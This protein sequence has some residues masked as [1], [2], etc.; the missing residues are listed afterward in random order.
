MSSTTQIKSGSRGGSFDA[1]EKIMVRY[2][3]QSVTTQACQVDAGCTEDSAIGTAGTI[4]KIPFVRKAGHW[5]HGRDLPGQ[6]IWSSGFREAFGHQ[7]NPHLPYKAMG[8]SIS[9]RGQV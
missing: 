7:E 9:R 4:W 6:G 8:T 1:K 3:T 2:V 5:R